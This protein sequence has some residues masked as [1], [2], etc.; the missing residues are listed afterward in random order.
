MPILITMEQ[1]KVL[2]EKLKDAENSIEYM[3][4]EHKKIL[5]GLHNEISNL[6]Q[7]C[8]GND[9]KKFLFPSMN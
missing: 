8:S 4:E 9:F 5:E 6:Q 3:K 7:K 2:D 1:A